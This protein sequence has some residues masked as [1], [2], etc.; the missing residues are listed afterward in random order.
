MV[1][2]ATSNFNFRDFTISAS[3]PTAVTAGSSGTST[4]TLTVLNGFTGTITISDTIP[5]GLSCGS[6]TPSSVSRSGTAT[7][8]CSANSQRDY[9]LTLNGTSGSLAH[10][11]TVHFICG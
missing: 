7:L 11:A 2:S 6:V 5:S 10:Q 9:T 4:V 3:S 8:S 1:H